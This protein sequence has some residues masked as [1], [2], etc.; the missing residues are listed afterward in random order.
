[1]RNQQ[2]RLRHI[3][4]S[5][6]FS[7]VLFLVGSSQPYS[8]QEEQFDFAISE[9]FLK[10]LADGKTIQPVL[11]IQLTARTG[12]GVHTLAKDCEIHIA[13]I[14]E[15]N[16]G[17]PN[18]IVVEPPN[19]CKFAPEGVEVRP[20]TQLREKIWPKILDD[21][22]M[23]KHCEV[24]GFIR[25]FTEHAQGSIDP[26]NPNHVFEIHPAMSIKAGNETLSFQNFLTAFEGMS[27]VKPTTTASCIQ[28]RKL[29]V[30]YNKTENQYEFRG[31]GGRCGNFAII[32]VSNVRKEWIRSLDG[33]HSAIARISPDGESTTTLK[34]YTLTGSEAD[35][36]LQGL[37]DGN[38]SSQ[39]VLLL[40][41]FT[42]DYF[43]IVRAVRTKDGVWPQ[44]QNWN[45]VDFPLAF[46]V[47]GQTEE[48]PWEEE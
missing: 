39:R 9:S 46:V 21:K 25:I 26:A 11:K 43:S 6:I 30:R 14:P 7:I 45:R 23:N 35:S 2:K 3:L 13:G 36:W 8:N 5:C 29:E 20:E 37:M 24:Q 31:E 27:H 4:F 32:E 34:L 42:Y 17:Y 1:M 40:G 28:D 16:L 12:R 33:G 18:D 48:I 47:F 10:M 19:L 44:D 38:R 22:I 15:L 41:L